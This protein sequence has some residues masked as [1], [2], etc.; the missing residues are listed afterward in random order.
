M[1]SAHKQAPD[2]GSHPELEQPQPVDGLRGIR[3]G[4]VFERAGLDETKTSWAR[5]VDEAGV[6]PESVVLHV[7]AGI[8]EQATQAIS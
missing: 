8:Y 7:G 6:G 1:K 2:Q 4:D 5:V 3:A